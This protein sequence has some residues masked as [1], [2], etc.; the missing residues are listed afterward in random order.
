M[1]QVVACYVAWNEAGQ[2]AESLRSVKAYVDRYVVVDA[3][4]DANPAAGTHS[5]DGTRDIC[6]SICAPVPLTYIES[7]VRLT[8][9]VARNRYLDELDEGDWPL[10]IDGDEVLYGDHDEALALFDEI[11]AGIDTHAL[12]VPVYTTAVLFD[13]NAPDVTVAAYATNPTVHTWG[14]QPRLFQNWKALR[15]RV[16]QF[17]VPHG[18][19]DETGEFVGQGGLYEK[20]VFLINHHVRQ[21]YTGYQNDY[22]RETEEQARG[23][24]GAGL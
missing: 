7:D 14:W 24:K 21:S 20:R 13:G 6:E 22:A 16:N 15:Y 10:I 2:I 1:S 23:L 5:A 11:R 8:Q 18:V 9:D 3:V 17:G 4:F 19:Y 12:L